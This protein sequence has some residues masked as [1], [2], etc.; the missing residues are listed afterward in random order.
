[1]RIRKTSKTREMTKIEK[2]RRKRTQK[3]K[4]PQKFSEDPFKITREKKQEN[5]YFFKVQKMKT[6]NKTRNIKPKFSR[7]TE[8]KK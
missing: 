1:M 7:S 2:K 6:R 8:S 5:F 3:L 4:N